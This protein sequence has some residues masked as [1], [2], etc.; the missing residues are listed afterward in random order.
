MLLV[1][2]KAQQWS[3]VGEIPPESEVPVAA[4]E[5]AFG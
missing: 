5:R 3:R 1:M 4:D 2:E